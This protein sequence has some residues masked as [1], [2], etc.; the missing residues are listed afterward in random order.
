MLT[1]PIILMI[2]YIIAILPVSIIFK[3]IKYDNLKRKINKETKSYWI[4]REIVDTDMNNQ[5]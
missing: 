5:Y 1:S 4:K 3:I 2:I